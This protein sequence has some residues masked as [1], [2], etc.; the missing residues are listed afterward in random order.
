[1]R[2]KVVQWA[3]G[4]IGSHVVRSFVDRDNLELAGLYVYSNEKVGRDAGEIVGLD[5]KLGVRATGDINDILSLDADVVIYTPRAS[6]VYGEK[7]DSNIDDICQLLASGKNV[8]TTVG[9]LY[10]T[11]HGPELCERLDK[12]CIS[13]QST[14]HATGFNPGYISDLLPLTMSSLSKTIKKITVSEVSSF[15]EYPSPVI[16]YDIMGFG[17]T[18]EKFSK[19]VKRYR[20]W[21]GGL[22]KESI[23]TNI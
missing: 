21:I 23:H 5:K 19:E 13:G 17:K 2:Y 4:A 9:Y 11:Y 16:F 15:E 10:P 22:F 14:Y 8:I 20:S 18:D 7:E 3:A 1:M 12:A 6:L